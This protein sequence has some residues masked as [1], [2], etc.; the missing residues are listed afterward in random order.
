MTEKAHNPDN[1]EVNRDYI[2]EQPRE[3]QDQNSCDQSH[4][5]RRD[6]VNSHT[7]PY[8]VKVSSNMALRRVDFFSNP[9]DEKKIFCEKITV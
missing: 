7:S 4:N 1:D 3:N 8:W 2:V 5:G 9:L 6:G